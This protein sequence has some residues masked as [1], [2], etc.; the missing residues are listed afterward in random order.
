MS[1][2]NEFIAK[3]R[4]L[5]NIELP[6]YLKDYLH[7]H[8]QAMAIGDIGPKDYEGL[9]DGDPAVKG[10][11]KKQARES[12]GLN[13]K[14][15]A[16]IE[17]IQQLLE[18]H[19]GREPAFKEE[20]DRLLKE[21]DRHKGQLEEFFKANRASRAGRDG[22]IVLAQ[23]QFM[24]NLC[25]L[26]EANDFKTEAK[27]LADEARLKAYAIAND[28]EAVRIDHSTEGGRE[29]TSAP[30]LPSSASLPTLTP[31]IE[32]GRFCKKIG[33]LIGLVSL[34]S[35]YAFVGHFISI[36]ICDK[37]L[38]SSVTQ[39]MGA[40]ID[41]LPQTE[42]NIK[43]IERKQQEI[44]DYYNGNLRAIQVAQSQRN[45]NV[46]NVLGVALGERPAVTGTAARREMIGKLYTFGEGTENHF[47]E[48]L[49]PGHG[50]A[51]DAK[52]LAFF[53]QRGRQIL[54]LLHGNTDRRKEFFDAFME[55][56]NKVT[57]SSESEGIEAVMEAFITIFNNPQGREI[58]TSL[59]IW[60]RLALLPKEIVALAFRLFTSWRA[61][62][63][64][65]AGAEPG[66]PKPD[67]ACLLQLVKLGRI[68][69]VEVL[70]GSRHANSDLDVNQG[71]LHVAVFH[72]HHRLVAQLID[73]HKAKIDA[74]F[75]F[76]GKILKPEDFILPG[77]PHESKL[78]DNLTAYTRVTVMPGAGNEIITGA[79]ARKTKVFDIDGLPGEI[80]L[81]E[82]IR[83][84]REHLAA[85]EKLQT[86]FALLQQVLTS[87]EATAS[88]QFDALMCFKR[89]MAQCT[90]PNMRDV[91]RQYERQVA[92]II[93]ERL[94]GWVEAIKRDLPAPTIKRKKEAGAEVLA[95][96]IEQTGDGHKY[97]RAT[98][99][100]NE[101]G[102]VQS[103]INWQAIDP[104]AIQAL[105]RLSVIG[106]HVN[107]DNASDLLERLTAFLSGLSTS[108]NKE[109]GEDI[110]MLPRSGST[111]VD[112]IEL[113][114]KAK[115]VSPHKFTENLLKVL[116]LVR[117]V[118]SLSNL[119]NGTYTGPGVSNGNCHDI[120]RE[121]E[122]K[123]M[124]L[125]PRMNVKA[126]LDAIARRMENIQQ[127]C[128]RSTESIEIYH[129][130]LDKVMGELSLLWELDSSNGIFDDSDRENLVLLFNTIPELMDNS[131]Q[132]LRFKLELVAAPTC[133][134][135]LEEAGF[136][137]E[138][139]KIEDFNKIKKS[140]IELIGDL[141][142]DEK[143]L[144]HRNN[145]S[146]CKM[147]GLG[148][149]AHTEAFQS[150]LGLLRAV[151][152]DLY[153]SESW[154]T[155]PVAMH[156]FLTG[157][158]YKIEEGEEL[159]YDALMQCYQNILPKADNM[160]LLHKQENCTFGKVKFL[161]FQ[162]HH[163]FNLTTILNLIKIIITERIS[164]LGDR[165]SDEKLRAY[166]ENM[167]DNQIPSLQKS[168]MQLSARV[169]K[170]ERVVLREGQDQ[171]L[172]EMHGRRHV[173]PGRAR[174][175]SMS[176]VGGDYSATSQAGA[177]EAVDM[178]L[179][180]SVS[181]RNINGGD[182][183]Q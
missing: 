92:D 123:A 137:E 50:R 148:E 134:S 8:L 130:E 159:S 16:A 7:A 127:R 78:R 10:R 11:K 22:I 142:R 112:L 167:R 64:P 131:D 96:E 153:E 14:A 38:L 48:V 91:I 176:A 97:R 132:R 49:M 33:E 124:A 172:E 89:V 139:T 85:H 140:I 24:F 18:A 56:L 5:E 70:L 45:E 126:Y 44:I 150:D 164:H 59:N 94:E 80:F 111:N 30:A 86:E 183:P 41:A 6:R 25:I 117:G 118:L 177:G 146:T 63:S 98:T 23:S 119:E 36:D 136:E 173:N 182:S 120:C 1:T 129:A 62:M 69:A 152:K 17:E 107:W 3:I 108:I 161:E 37:N 135:R 171:G 27:P 104:D 158:V 34:E 110:E 133:T 157:Q 99:L 109:T 13:A 178:D 113:L 68:E 114:N 87:E 73:K 83:G 95:D 102:T 121:I 72:G 46:L 162:T 174:S 61:F 53:Q 163:S 42:L 93:G 154:L 31:D 143:S 43:H 100:P 169:F 54:Q 51:D 66:L 105:E 116:L 4:E 122:A 2:L 9:P 103:R 12:T 29:A 84:R 67:N 52:V 115:E 180:R 40:A 26:N 170:M 149:N 60:Q 168:I 151:L 144:N 55:Y 156:F 145:S 90:R 20:S 15:M 19:A 160:A 57:A 71:A 175:V 77:H 35:Y 65:G 28:G 39:A 147:L 128:N 101:E 74:A 76:D 81:Q 125:L 181:M 47:A 58:Y 32:L 21:L 155:S 88:A 138:N 79:D 75:M 106:C 141:I 165:D 179:L 82:A 166:L